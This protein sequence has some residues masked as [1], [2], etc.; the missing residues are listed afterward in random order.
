MPASASSCTGARTRSRGSRLPGRSWF[1]RWRPRFPNRPSPSA[2]MWLWRN[3][4]TP[5]PI[6]LGSGSAWLVRRAWATSFSRRSTT[7]AT[8]CSTPLE[9]HTSR[10]V[11]RRAETC[12]RNS[13]KPVPPRTC[14]WVSTTR[15][16][17]CTIRAIGILRGRWWRT[18][19]ES[20]TAHSGRATSTRWKIISANSSRTMEMS[21]SSGST[22]SSIISATSRSVSGD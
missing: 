13:Q 3:A 12:A 19:P 8:A 2:T 10:R 22:A 20:R 15:R 11:H 6:G 17:T 18:G 7:T 21:P 16:P 14:H 5:R 4:S 9:R 1:R